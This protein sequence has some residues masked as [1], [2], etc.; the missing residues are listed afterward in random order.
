MLCRHD[1]RLM[2]HWLSGKAMLCVETLGYGGG[3]GGCSGLLC[4]VW[5]LFVLQLLQLRCEAH[6]SPCCRL[7]TMPAAHGADC[8]TWRDLMLLQH[9]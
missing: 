4:R 7:L 8:A 1:T 3:L 9:M 5:I 2:G 6:R